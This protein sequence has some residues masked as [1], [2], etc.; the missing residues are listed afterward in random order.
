MNLVSRDL[1]KGNHITPGLLRIGQHHARCADTQSLATTRPT[2]GDA[3]SN[4]ESNGSPI[5]RAE[6]R[7]MNT[8]YPIDVGPNAVP[9]IHD[10]AGAGPLADHLTSH[11]PSRPTQEPFS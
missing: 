3:I 9:A 6:P 5:I 8:V 10:H 4:S 1:K 2:F 7:V 11:C